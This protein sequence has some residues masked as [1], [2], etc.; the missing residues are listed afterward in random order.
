MGTITT[1][2]II[3]II[4]RIVIIVIDIVVDRR[5]SIEEQLSER[6]E[7]A[8]P[9][10][11][12]RALVREA[13]ERVDDAGALDVGVDE[14]REAEQARGDGQQQRAQRGGHVLH[15]EHRHEHVDQR[16]VDDRVGD[17]R[18]GALA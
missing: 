11:D 2:I 3:N 10:L 5:R 6:G 12:G 17:V 18:A 13:A 4:S 14:G 7:C 1:S 8:A 15:V 9:H 16:R